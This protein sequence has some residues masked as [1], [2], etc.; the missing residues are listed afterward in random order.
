RCAA[1]SGA[2]RPRGVPSSPASYI[3]RS[4]LVGPAVTLLVALV[5]VSGPDLH[6]V[7][8]P[9]HHG[10]L[11]NPH[12]RPQSLRDQQASLGV[13][14]HGLGLAEEHP[15]VRAPFGVGEG[16]LADLTRP[17]LPF[18]P[19]EAEQAPV[20]PEREHRA[21]GER[22]TEPGG[23]ADPAFRVELVAVRAEQFGHASSPSPPLLSTL[24]HLYS[25]RS[26]GER[27]DGSRTVNDSHE[28]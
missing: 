21:L 6:P 4:R 14:L 11:A 23:Q 27:E 12:L 18:G 5:G 1:G 16:K 2:A 3:E 8:H 22:L 24:C 17:A 20:L 25:T 7:V 26:R 13:E 9:E 10:L 19:G 15:R 28:G